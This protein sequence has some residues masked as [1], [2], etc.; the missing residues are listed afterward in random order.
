MLLDDRPALDTVSVKT[1]STNSGLKC[2]LGIASV[3]LVTSS[4][5][6]LLSTKQDMSRDNNT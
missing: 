5:V 6:L 1:K 2:E 3:L 4:Q